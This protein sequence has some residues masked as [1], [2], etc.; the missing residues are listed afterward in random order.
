[1]AKHC[2]SMVG[3]RKGPSRQKFFICFSHLFS[4]VGN[5]FPSP[6]QS[7]VH[8]RGDC[9][10]LW[11]ETE[12]TAQR[13]SKN[14]KKWS[15]R[16]KDKARE[17]RTA[18]RRTHAHWNVL[19]SRRKSTAAHTKHPTT[20]EAP[21]NTTNT[22]FGSS[23]FRV[24]ASGGLWTRPRLQPADRRV[25]QHTSN[26][27]RKHVLESLLFCYYGMKSSFEKAEKE[28]TLAEGLADR[29]VLQHTLD[30]LN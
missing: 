28:T 15:H 14:Q 25:F 23:S 9:A 16:P 4:A 11:R 1:M 6:L 26:T 8:H 21:A 20:E 22:P 5:I 18:D 27:N 30:C 19:L 29:R 3:S 10:P 12:K 7:G 13:K 24:G 2:G 17:H